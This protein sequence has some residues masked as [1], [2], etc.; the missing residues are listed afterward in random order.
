MPVF[1]GCLDCLYRLIP[2]R[3]GSLTLSLSMDQHIVW[4]AKADMIDVEIYNF[5]GPCSAVVEQAQ[6]GVIPPTRWFLDIDMSKNM[7]YLFLFQISQHMPG[8]TFERHGK[9]G[10]TVGDE[11]GIGRCKISEECMDGR[12]PDVSGSSAILSPPP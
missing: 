3:T 6:Q 12:Q 11:T 2:D 5:L 4:A 7:Q 9:N 8:V 10:L 1:N